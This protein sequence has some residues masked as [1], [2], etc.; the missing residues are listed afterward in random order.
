MNCFGSKWI[1]GLRLVSGDWRLKVSRSSRCVLLVATGLLA[2][3]CSNDRLTP[4]DAQRLIESSAR[5]SAPNV[6]TVR[7]QYCTTVNAPDENLMAGAG[8]LKALEAAG[9][10]RVERRAAAPNECTALPGPMRERLMIT[11]ADSSATFHPRPLDDTGLGA[12]A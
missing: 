2:A 6:L 4:M 10:I 1:G 5:F 3:R 7:S 8:R 11:L 12:G 9:A